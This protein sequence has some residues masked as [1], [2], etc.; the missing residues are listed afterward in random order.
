MQLFFKSNANIRDIISQ[1]LRNSLNRYSKIKPEEYEV[2]DEW[3]DLLGIS[4]ISEKKFNE[5][6]AGEQ[7]L[8]LLARALIKQPSMLVLDEPLHGLDSSNKYRVKKIIDKM[9]ENN[10]LL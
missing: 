2:T 1:G 10:N 8:V 7:R 9:V 3:M 4:N 6:S 5:L